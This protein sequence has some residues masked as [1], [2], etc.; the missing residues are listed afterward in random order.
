M[1]G[2]WERVDFFANLHF[3]AVKRLEDLTRRRK[4]T[5]E[6]RC[7]VQRVRMFLCF[8]CGSRTV[9]IK[10]QQEGSRSHKQP[11]LLLKCSVSKTTIR[12]GCC[13]HATFPPHHLIAL[14]FLF[15][16]FLVNVS[17]VLSVYIKDD[18][19][20]SLVWEWVWICWGFWTAEGNKGSAVKWNGKG[21]AVIEQVWICSWL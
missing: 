21:L 9:S 17:V 14:L 7:S 13:S 12:C 19:I 10:S 11:P 3:I 5:G 6:S 1:S 4:K 2:V 18:L 20:H 16:F 8:L 15:F